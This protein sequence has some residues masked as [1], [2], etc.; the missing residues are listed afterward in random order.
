MLVLVP[1]H[2]KEHSIGDMP[3]ALLAQTRVPPRI[4]VI[5][6]QAP[7]LFISRYAKP[8]LDSYG[9]RSPHC[10]IRDKPFTEAASLSRVRKALARTPA[11]TEP[12]RS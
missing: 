9:V 7:A 3:N 11:S 4:V 2:N 1:A 10:D 6:R 8:I 12:D 5:R